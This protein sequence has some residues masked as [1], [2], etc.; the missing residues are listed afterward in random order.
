[1]A[2]SISCLEVHIAG[3]LCAVPVDAIAEVAEYPVTPPPPLSRAEVGGLVLLQDEVATLI[4]LGGGRAEAG[5]PRSV[6][7]CLL[8]V[9]ERSHVRYA[10]AVEE[11]GRMLDLEVHGRRAGWLVAARDA[12]GR[13]LFVFDFTAARREL[14]GTQTAVEGAAA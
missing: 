14:E 5:S 9:P 3:R 11:V 2:V 6:Q 10:L 12:A 1:M 4:D 7:K 8:L 13:E